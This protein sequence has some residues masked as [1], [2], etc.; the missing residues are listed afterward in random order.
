MSDDASS[1]SADGAEG[2]VDL[3][4]NSDAKADLSSAD[5]REFKSAE[6]EPLVSLQL[7]GRVRA[8]E[9]RVTYWEAAEPGK[10]RFDGYQLTPLSGTY[11]LLA[12]E[13]EGREALFD[14]QYRPAPA[15]Q[16]TLDLAIEATESGSFTLEVDTLQHLPSGWQVI[17]RK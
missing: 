6:N 11:H 8:E 5:D 2:S 12:S 14:S 10:D 7:T 16:D 15:E 4:V 1:S 9:T 13:M 17:L 3:K